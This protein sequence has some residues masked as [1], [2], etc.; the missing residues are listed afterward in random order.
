MWVRV[1]YKI[2]FIL[3]KVNF[4]LV[5]FGWWIEIFCLNLLVVVK[6]YFIIKYDKLKMEIKNIK[7]KKSVDEWFK[8]IK[9]FY[10]CW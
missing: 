3:V 7:K 4:F 1:Y 8:L 9:G 10:N 6:F 2:V 5:Y